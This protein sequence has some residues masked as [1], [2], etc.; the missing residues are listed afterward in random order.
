MV[1]W[2][3]GRCGAIANKKYYTREPSLSG[4][5][6]YRSGR[7]YCNMCHEYQWHAAVTKDYSVLAMR[8][9]GKW[10]KNL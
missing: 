4:Y 6:K 1:N 3:C 7:I 5:S 9:N 10:K 8:K 2:M